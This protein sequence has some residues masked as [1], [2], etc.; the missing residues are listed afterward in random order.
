MNHTLPLSYTKAYSHS[1]F[2]AIPVSNHKYSRFICS[3]RPQTVQHCV[4]VSPW[5]QSV[6]VKRLHFNFINYFNWVKLIPGKKKG[7][8]SCSW[9]KPPNAW[10]RLACGRASLSSPHLANISECSVTLKYLNARIEPIFSWLDSRP[11]SPLRN[12]PIREHQHHRPTIH[13]PFLDCFVRK[14]KW[15]QQ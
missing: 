15:F 6:S 3:Q 5:L 1:L 2:T 10:G 8:S 4:I 14:A 7:L 11:S 9:K 12:R 13:R